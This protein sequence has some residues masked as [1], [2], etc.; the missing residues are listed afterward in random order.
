MRGKAASQDCVSNYFT[1][2][3]KILT[4]YNLKDIFIFNVDENGI[5]TGGVKPPSIV[6]SKDKK[7]QIVTSERAQTVTVLGCGSAS[8]TFISPYF[9]FPGKRLLPEL[10]EGATPGCDGTVSQTGSGYSNTDFF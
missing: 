6:T 1:E 4:K 5:N 10:L 8:G 9:V 2:L 7:E 3:E